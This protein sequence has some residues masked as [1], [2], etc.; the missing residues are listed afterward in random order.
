MSQVTPRARR[1]IVLGT[2]LGVVAMTVGVMLYR[3]RKRVIAVNKHGLPDIDFR[4]EDSEILHETSWATF[5]S[6]YLLFAY[7]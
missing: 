5:A 1:R 4:T 3:R 6:D 2:A 7:G